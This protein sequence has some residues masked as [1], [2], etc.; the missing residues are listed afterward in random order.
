MTIKK[1]IVKSKTSEECVCFIC[2]ERITSEE[3]I[4]AAVERNLYAAAH[5]ICYQALLA[6]VTKNQSSAQSRQI[7]LLGFIEEIEGYPVLLR[8]DF[9]SNMPYV[10]GFFAYQREVSCYPN[11]LSNW[12]ETNGVKISNP[13][14]YIRKLTLA[15]KLARIPDGEGKFRY[16][17][18][19]T[20]YDQIIQI[21]A[22]NE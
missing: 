4:E 17:I 3:K 16:I 18:T 15:G 20:G 5:E 6:L 19:R 13:Y 10:L 2:S 7:E 22:E 12:L 11:D 9:K 1:Y 21:L 8:R 14:D